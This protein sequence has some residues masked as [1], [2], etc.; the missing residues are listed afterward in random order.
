MDNA[1][2]AERQ[3]AILERIYRHW[4]TSRRAQAEQSHSR[5]ALR[6]FTITLARESGTP[7]TSVACEVG[8]LLN[9]PVYD[10]ELL[11]LVARDMGVRASLL[12]SVDEKRVSW[13]REAIQTFLA[14]PQVRGNAYVH[15]LVES[16]LALASHGECVIVGRGAAHILPP[17]TTLRVRLVAPVA[18]RVAAFAQRLGIPRDEAARRVE[19]TD[20]ERVSFVRDH[21]LKDATD[22]RGYDL[23]LNAAHFSVAA[24]A[25]I[26]V[27]SLSRKQGGAAASSGFASASTY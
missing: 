25:E 2:L 16:V 14:V 20:R 8:R 1:T 6:A 26:V 12:D 23:L 4:E 24:C 11:E 22:P 3:A 13:L 5:S 9:W 17:E 10:Q 27:K 15:H 21:F 18:E 7:G 19:A